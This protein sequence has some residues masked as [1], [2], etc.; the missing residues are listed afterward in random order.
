MIWLKVFSFIIC[1]FFSSHW[2]YAAQQ[3]EYILDEQPAIDSASKIQGSLAK[4]FE[5]FKDKMALFPRIK[6]KLENLPPFFRD[7]R[8]TAKF[9]SYY[10][11]RDREKTHDSQAW[12]YGGSLEYN[13]GWWQDSLQI[14]ASIY[15]SQKIVGSENK[16]GTLL[17]KPGQHGFVTLGEAYLVARLTKNLTAKVFRQTLNLPYLNKQDS[18]MVPNT[19][20]AYILT[21]PESSLKWIV[22]YVRKMKK[23]N[24]DKFE[25]MSQVAGVGGT[26]KGLALV[27]ARYSITEH[28]DIGAINYFTEDYM[29]TFYTEGNHVF[30]PNNEIPVQLSLQYTNQQSTGSEI[31]GN[32]DTYSVG[33][34][35]SMSYQ[36]LVLTAAA[37]STGKNSGLQKP[38][39]GTPSFLSIMVED[40]DRA[41]ENAWL[42]GLSYHFKR[43]GLDGLSAYTNYAYGNTPDSGSIA[44]PDQ[45][46]W[47]ITVD[48]K[49]QKSLFNGL[50]LRLRRASVNRNNSGEDLTDYRVILN[51]EMQFL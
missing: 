36:S 14:G 49:P 48:Y 7:T 37:T 6:N 20:E 50:W 40:F 34:K 8:F 26:H 25:Y 11:D 18:R 45:S 16:D 43:L 19:F 27:G 44:S 15:T 24:S 42:I 17:L 39:G 1:L 46:E 29:N 3:P 21:H 23:R 13:S 35:V 31:R 38:F 33:G 10:F 32:F 51:Y 9:R 30:F 4:T 5:R 2:V 22:G 47:D 41:G 12:T 28:T